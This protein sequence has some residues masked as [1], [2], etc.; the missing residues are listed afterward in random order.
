MEHYCTSDDELAF[1]NWLAKYRPIVNPHPCANGACDGKM[2]ETFGPE[3]DQ[4]AGMHS[5]YLWT[6]LEGDTGF[7]L[8]PGYH[9]VNRFGYFICEVPWDADATP[10]D[11]P[12]D[13]QTEV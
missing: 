10:D 8:S 2:F 11:V 12:Y 3:W 1:E 4:V 7:W 9:V 6:L 13:T 5:R